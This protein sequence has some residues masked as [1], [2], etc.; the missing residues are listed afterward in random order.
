MKK[1]LAVIGVG[2]ACAAVLCFG[3]TAAL[4]QNAGGARRAAGGTASPA[5]ALYDQT[6]DAWRKA[7]SIHYESA[8]EST[9]PGGSATRLIYRIWLKSRISP[10]SRPTRATRSKGRS[11]RTAGTWPHSGRDSRRRTSFTRTEHA[12]AGPDATTF[13]S[14][15][16]GRQESIGRD[17]G[18]F[19]IGLSL[20][21][22]P[23][24]FAGAADPM[25]QAIESGRVTGAEDV[26]GETCDV[27]V[28]TLARGIG[29][30]NTLALSNGPS[31]EKGRESPP[32]RRADDG[33]RDLV[34]LRAQWRR[35]ERPVHVRPGKRLAQAS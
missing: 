25:Q 11:S 21:V 12:D 27:L 2:A 19:G 7:D 31:A 34:V 14:H 22:D 15:P 16:A 5:E 32:Q 10:G 8:Y 13:A 24:M 6:V 35:G 20:I 28:M 18:I 26:G 33:Q 29:R 30:G 17:A 9:G 3:G 4:A 1:T 23:G